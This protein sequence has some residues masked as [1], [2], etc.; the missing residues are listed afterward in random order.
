MFVCMSVCLSDSVC[1]CVLVYV[2]PCVYLY[3]TLYACIPVGD[4]ALVD[5]ETLMFYLRECTCVRLVAPLILNSAFE[6]S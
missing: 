3:V 6:I 5:D 1:M 2:C 4:T